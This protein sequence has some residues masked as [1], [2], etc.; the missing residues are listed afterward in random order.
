MI[1]HTYRFLFEQCVYTHSSHHV[2]YPHMHGIRPYKSR[3]IQ[4]S[5]DKPIEQHVY[6]GRGEGDS[7]TERYLKI[8]DQQ[9]CSSSLKANGL[10]TQ[11]EVKFQFEFEGKKHFSQ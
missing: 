10:K 11:E 8:Q 7:Q 2:V 4:I 1:L 3:L 6:L 5:P 9:L